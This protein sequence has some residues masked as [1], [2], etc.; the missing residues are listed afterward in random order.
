MRCNHL[1][2]LLICIISTETFAQNDTTLLSPSKFEQAISAGKIQLIDVRTPE[3]F[4]KGRIA[5]SMMIDWKNKKEFESKTKSLDPAKPVYLY[6][7]AGVRSH[8]AAEY[9]R[10]KGFKEIYELNG[11]LNKWKEENKPVEK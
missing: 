10:E 3:E 5:N 8:A 2:L 9:L 4:Q 11:G 1:L 7:S 6:C